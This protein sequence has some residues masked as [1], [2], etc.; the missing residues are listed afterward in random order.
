MNRKTIDFEDLKKM[1]L[2][3]IEEFEPGDLKLS[4]TARESLK[5]EIHVEPDD[6]AA[7]LNAISGAYCAGYAA[8]FM[9]GKGRRVITTEVTTE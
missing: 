2:N 3:L 8:G 9:R 5:G 6:L 7:I 1:G 4:N